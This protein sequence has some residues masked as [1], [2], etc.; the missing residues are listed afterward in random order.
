MIIFNLICVD[1]EFTFEGWFEDSKEFSK[2]KKKNLINCPSCDSYN[3]NKGLMTP[4][5][6]RK[7]NSKNNTIKEVFNL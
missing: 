1:C 2:Q 4:N 3:I 5:I 6:S 7:S